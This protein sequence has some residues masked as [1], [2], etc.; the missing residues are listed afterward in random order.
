MSVSRIL[1]FT[2]DF[3]AKDHRE[4]DGNSRPPDSWLDGRSIIYTTPQGT[5]RN[6]KIHLC[7][8]CFG[9]VAGLWKARFGGFP[10]TRET[11]QDV[12]DDGPFQP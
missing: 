4:T 7:P 9:A 1:T 12:L 5:R 3:C 2:C 6:P 8:E 11:L 10:K